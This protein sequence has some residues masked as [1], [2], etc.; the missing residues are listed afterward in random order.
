MNL[1]QN[2]FSKGIHL[3]SSGH[4]GDIEICK[5]EVNERIIELV[6]SVYGVSKVWLKTG[7]GEMFDRKTD[8]QLG[9]MNILFNQLNDN[10]KGYAVKQIKNLVKLQLEENKK[11][12]SLKNSP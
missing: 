4:Y 5:H 12:E 8:N 3:K 9:E 11:K 2:Q 7:T 6:S 1:S 10:F